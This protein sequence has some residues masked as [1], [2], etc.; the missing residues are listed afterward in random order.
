MLE[1]KSADY[2]VARANPTKSEKV[3][4]PETVINDEI[5]KPVDRII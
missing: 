3:K 2:I 4:Y 5:E 1:K